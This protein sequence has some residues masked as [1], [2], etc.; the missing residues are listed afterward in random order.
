M[1]NILYM[2][3]SRDGFIADSNDETPWSDAE[4]EAFQEFAKS[5]EVVL[6]GKRTF[7]IM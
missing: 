1:A 6:L 3:I 7:Q 5:C 4:W 2:A